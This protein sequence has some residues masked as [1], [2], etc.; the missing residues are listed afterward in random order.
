MKKSEIYAN[1]VE[2][3][4]EILGENEAVE[5]VL[6]DHLAPKAGGGSAVNLDEVTRKDEDGV[7]TEILCSTSGVWL[8]ATVENFYEDKSETQ[9]L[10]MLMVLDLRDNQKQ[11][12]NLLKSLTKLREQLLQ[13]LQMIFLTLKTLTRLIVLK[14]N[15]EQLK[16]LNQT[17]QK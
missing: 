5:A 3:V 2:A 16:I 8:P 9:E 1:V 17:F 11:L 12:R 14:S 7:I 13:H 4:R 15:L 6:K 10:L